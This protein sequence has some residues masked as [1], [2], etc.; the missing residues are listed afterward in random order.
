MVHRRIKG[1][2]MKFKRRKRRETAGWVLAAGVVLTG[3]AAAYAVSR[4]LRSGPVERRLDMR[5]LEKRVL[6]ALLND[7][8]ARTESIDIA[9]VGPGILELAGAVESSEIAR[10]IVAVVDGVAGVHTV[11]N[12]LE[13]RTTEAQLKRNRSKTGGDATRW[14]GGS[15]GMGRRRQGIE[16]DPTQR[17]DHAALKARSLV[18]NRDD[19][20]QD[21][22]DGDGRGSRIG[23]ANSVGMHTHVAPHS[24]NPSDDEPGRPPSIAPH[25][26]AQRD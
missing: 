5:S 4:L 22:E 23:I 3:A 20:L 7:M 19:V 26:M 11:L 17:D 1:E 2:A 18:P 6:Q 10:H 16:T 8:H 24:P 25:E 15:V 12:R 14:Y 9:A 13:I 21:V